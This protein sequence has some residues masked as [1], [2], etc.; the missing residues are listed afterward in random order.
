[1]WE[2]IA[3][4]AAVGAVLGAWLWR[5]NDKA[6][7]NERRLTALETWRQVYSENFAKFEERIFRALERI[8]TKVDG[9]AERE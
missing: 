9:K 5:V 8:E 6:A 4:A 1:V 2:S 3:A 7:E